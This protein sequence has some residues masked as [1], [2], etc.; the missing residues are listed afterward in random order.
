M[1]GAADQRQDVSLICGGD[2]EMRSA[3]DE[4]ATT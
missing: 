1:E 4:D 3:V 2:E